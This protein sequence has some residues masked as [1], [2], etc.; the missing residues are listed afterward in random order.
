MKAVRVGVF[1]SHRPRIATREMGWLLCVSGQQDNARPLFGQVVKG[2]P[3]CC[4]LEISIAVGLRKRWL[5]ARS[6]GVT[7]GTSPRVRGGS[8]NRAAGWHA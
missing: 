4:Q 8:L 7:K 6:G 1:P 5:G 3:S 2:L